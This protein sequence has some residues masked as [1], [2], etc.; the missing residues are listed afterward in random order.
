MVEQD[1]VRMRQQIATLQKE[2]EKRELEIKQQ[3]SH[4]HVELEEEKGA[5]DKYTFRIWEGSMHAGMDCGRIQR[6]SE[7]GMMHADVKLY[8]QSCN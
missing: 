3:R 1:L 2:L 6:S 5:C 4:D 7:A 8:S